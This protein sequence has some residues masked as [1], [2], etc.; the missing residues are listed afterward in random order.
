M[1]IMNI[2]VMTLSRI[3]S[4]ARKIKSSYVLIDKDGSIYGFDEGL[5]TLYKSSN[6]IDNDGF[7][8]VFNVLDLLNIL[9]DKPIG[10][11]VS[12]QTSEEHM[13]LHAD[14]RNLVFM[15]H[16]LSHKINKVKY[17]T[18]EV[19]IMYDL[20]N[21][22]S[23]ELIARNIATNPKNGVIPFIY[24]HAILYIFKGLLPVLK[25]DKLSIRIYEKYGYGNMVV[26]HIDK[27]PKRK[28]DPWWSIDVAMN[29][30]FPEI[31]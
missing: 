4:E 23:D 15:Y 10:D 26:Y 3:L 21:M 13:F 16:E 22:E 14:I 28:K 27:K 18:S 6:K 11:D 1:S 12:I 30:L 19:P 7:I 25:G 8:Y 20:A 5:Y 31:D 24:N 29:C 17:I 2:S 9:K